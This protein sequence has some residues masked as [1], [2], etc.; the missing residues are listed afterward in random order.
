MDIEQLVTQIAEKTGI[1]PDLT[2]KGIQMV[3]GFVK[4]KLPPTVSGQID[5]FLAGQT[6]TTPQ[7]EKATTLD[8]IAGAVSQYTGIPDTVAK[9]VV[10]MAGTFLAEK[11]P[12][13][14][15]DQVKGVLGI[16]GEHAGILEQAKE[17]F[18]GLFGH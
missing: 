4:T 6:I 5:T 10:Q 14:F 13:P 16:T 12:A 3:G 2:R 17:M 7:L 8:Q 1:S 11:L 18:G 15:G 9:T